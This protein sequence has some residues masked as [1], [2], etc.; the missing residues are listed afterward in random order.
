MGPSLG[1]RYPTLFG[2]TEPAHKTKGLPTVPSPTRGLPWS[3]EDAH[4]TMEHR[5]I[6]V[7]VLVCALTL[8]SLAQG[9]QETCTVA[10]HHRDNCGSPGIT[11]SQCKDKGCC[12]DN[13]VRGVPWCY[14]PVAVDNPP[15]APKNRRSVPSS[16]HHCGKKSAA[17]PHPQRLQLQ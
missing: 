12:F 6:Y 2:Q 9:Q 8:S 5:V 14:Y 13:T 3:R 1:K 10:P 4:A 7:L 16:V 15:E 11:P 17:L